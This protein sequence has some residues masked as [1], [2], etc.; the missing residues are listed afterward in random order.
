MITA[1]QIHIS[2]KVGDNIGNLFEISVNVLCDPLVLLEH[3]PRGVAV[4]ESN[5]IC[6]RFVR[7]VRD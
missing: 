1:F 4:G 5:A 7:S 3:I 2:W 6:C